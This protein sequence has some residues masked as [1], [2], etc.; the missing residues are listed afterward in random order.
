VKESQ[1]KIDLQA[2]SVQEN[3]SFEELLSLRK[4]DRSSLPPNR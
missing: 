4:K 3:L 2:I 1:Y